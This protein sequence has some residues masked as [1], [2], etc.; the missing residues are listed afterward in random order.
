MEKNLT[1]NLKKEEELLKISKALANKGR[2][3]ILKLLAIESLSVYEISKKLNSP[4]STI[5]S[6][7][8]ILEEANLIRYKLQGGKH[9]TLKLC[10][11]VYE[12]IAINLIKEQDTSLKNEKFINIPIGSYYDFNIKPTCGLV[13]EKGY[14]AKDDDPNSFYSPLRSE[15]ELL[16]FNQGYIEY[17]IPLDSSDKEINVI[18]LSLELCSEAPYYRNIWPSDITFFF[19]NVEAL[20]YKCPGDFG[21]RSG[22][23]TPS[24]W[25]KNATQFGLLKTISISNSG[26]YLDFVKVSDVTLKDLKLHQLNNILTI[27]IMI[28]DDAKNIGGINI[29]G[30]KFGDYNQDIVL[31]ITYKE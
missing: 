22:K 13:G 12:K 8:A 27:K 30:S 3:D 10:S 24:W 20:T 19:N 4:M 7:L 16:W 23:L 11:I 9:G 31:K 18:S 28:K 1:L 14:L 2:I 26:T 15:A 17:K 29:F 6:N 21:G 25:P 5:C